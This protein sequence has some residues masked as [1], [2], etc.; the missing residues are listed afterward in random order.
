MIVPQFNNYEEFENTIR[1]KECYLLRND[2]TFWEIADYGR[3]FDRSYKV[4]LKLLDT[5]KKEIELKAIKNTDHL[6]EY[7]DSDF[8]T[9]DLWDF[10]INNNMNKKWKYD[11]LLLIEEE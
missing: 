8:Y 7:Y 1:T 2:N 3:F 10:I 4:M 6:L 11:Y 5:D 9:M